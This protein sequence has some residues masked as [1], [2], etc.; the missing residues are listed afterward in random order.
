MLDRLIPALVS[1]LKMREEYRPPDIDRVIDVHVADIEWLFRSM[2]AYNGRVSAKRADDAT[3]RAAS[4]NDVV[5]QRPHGLHS[6]NAPPSFIDYAC[7]CMTIS[8]PVS[9]QS[10]HGSQFELPDSNSE[11]PLGRD[12][13]YHCAPRTKAGHE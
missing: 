2:N 3:Q 10:T 4:K 9:S 11:K 13:I 8:R 6:A 1:E 7:A 5:V 12:P